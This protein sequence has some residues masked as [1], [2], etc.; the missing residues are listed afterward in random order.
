MLL[1]AATLER[2]LAG[3][4]QWSQLSEGFSSVQ[5]LIDAC[6]LDETG[7]VNSAV[8]VTELIAETYVLSAEIYLQCRVCRRVDAFSSSGR[9]SHVGRRPRRHP[10]VQQKLAL[11][12]RCLEIMPYSGPLFTAQN[13]L[14]RPYIAGIVAVQPYDRGVIQEWF[15]T[16]ISGPRGV[17]H[18]YP[19]LY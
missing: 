4:R 7:K 2:R 1:S 17:S 12:I 15:E 8:R 10:V 6:A 19:I 11:L 13:P 5:A 14:L 9:Y 16:V 3:L 18:T